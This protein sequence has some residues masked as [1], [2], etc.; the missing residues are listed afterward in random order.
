[1]SD[2]HPEQQRAVEYLA[3]KGTAAP[4]ETLRSQARAAFESIERMFDEVAIDQ[5]DR[6][7]AEGKWSRRQILDHL[8]L[9]HAPAIAQLGSLLGGATPDGVAI[10]AGLHSAPNE[11]APWSDLRNRLAETHREILALIDGASNEISLE[12]KAVVEIVVKVDSKP[13]H[14]HV[15][16][17]WK[18]FVQAIRVHTLEHRDQLQRTLHA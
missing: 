9:S 1:M 13:L 4:V 16:I 15:R 6:A 18:A 17:D 2:L 14:W 7:P 8:V 10:P 3:R 11:L 5:R 12:P